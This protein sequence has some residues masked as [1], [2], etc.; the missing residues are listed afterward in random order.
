MA[1]EANNLQAQQ[2]RHSHAGDNG[3][4]FVLET[5]AGSGRV[6]LRRRDSRSR[7]VLQGWTSNA[8]GAACDTN[9]NGQIS[10]RAREQ[11]A[12]RE[13]LPTRAEQGPHGQRLRNH[14]HESSVASRSKVNLHFEQPNRNFGRYDR[15]RWGAVHHQLQNQTKSE[16]V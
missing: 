1:E 8:S 9:S 10:Q 2:A 4:N 12:L 11:L 7:R 16:R 5:E 15:T 6:Q 3:H 13:H 14:Q